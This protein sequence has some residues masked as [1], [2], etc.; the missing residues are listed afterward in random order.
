MKQPGFTFIE[1]IIAV[2]IFAIIAVSIYS[3][4]SAG[5]RMW[6]KTSPMIDEN[7]GLRMFFNTISA[8]LKRAVAYYDNSA[9]LTKPGFG[10]EYEGELNFAGAP[11]RISFMTIVRVSDP[12]LGLRAEPAKV[13]Y[14]YDISDRAVKRLV[15]TKAEGL[16]EDNAKSVDMLINIDEKDFSFEYCYKNMISNS[17]YEY[18]WKD[19]WKDENARTIPRG[20]RV[21]AGE[22]ERT[23]FIPTGVL[24]EER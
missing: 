19:A 22:F 1:L 4:F 3:T 21:R 23:V 12:E 15:A 13:I 11:R 5:I 7:R 14:L 9:A 6:L 20:V 24:G 18:E 17:D 10:Q 8:D 16:D 2:T